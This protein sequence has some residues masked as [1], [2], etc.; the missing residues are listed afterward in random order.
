MDWFPW[1]LTKKAIV[2]FVGCTLITPQTLFASPVFT[3]IMYDLENGSDSGREWV[4]VQNIVNSNVVLGTYKLFENK[5]N[6]DIKYVRGNRSLA[7]GEYAIIAVDGNK[8]LTDHPDFSGNLFDSSFSLSNTEE[9]LILR[10]AKLLDVDFVTYTSTQGA[11]GNGNSLQRNS[12]GVWIENS[13]T[14]GSG[15]AENPAR[16]EI[17]SEI[18]SVEIPKPVKVESSNAVPKSGTVIDK[19]NQSAHLEVVTGQPRVIGESQ[20]ESTST[21]IGDNKSLLPWAIG[22]LMIIGTAV[23]SFLI[24]NSLGKKENMKTTDEADEYEII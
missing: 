5:V 8:F 9:T 22:L 15:N 11:S 3:E 12:R 13:P 16:K 10:D 18:V 2:V 20:K 23:A 1:K 24:A 6:H 19:R 17:K 14:P 4:E 7:K 21:P